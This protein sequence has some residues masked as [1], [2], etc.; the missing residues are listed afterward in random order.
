[1]KNIK[2]NPKISLIFDVL[3]LF[4]IFIAAYLP[5]AEIINEF[6]KSGKTSIDF[7]F[8]VK[9]YIMA[10]IGSFLILLSSMFR[11]RRFV[12]SLISFTVQ[13][14]S[15]GIFFILILVLDVRISLVD[16]YFKQNLYLYFL[17]LIY[18]IGSVMMMITSIIAIL[19]YNVTLKEPKI[20]KTTVKEKSIKLKYS[21]EK[22]EPKLSEVTPKKA[23]TEKSKTQ[24]NNLN[25]T[26][27]T[28]EKTKKAKEEEV[29]Q[30]EV[31]PNKPKTEKSKTQENHL[32]KTKPTKEKT[33]KTKS[34]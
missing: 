2:V 18:L 26:K 25:K 21:K 17:Y 24:V 22:I 20:I 4:L 13:N 7:L 30:S 31:I 29:Q 9:P 11:S 14:L 27:P 5:L 23:K 10:L 12:I 34:N 32:N 16:L 8:L 15:M 28:K 6:V 33:S 1:M 19:D 3:A